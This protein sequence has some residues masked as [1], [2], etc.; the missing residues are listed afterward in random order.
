MSARGVDDG[1]ISGW[2]DSCSNMVG[3]AIVREVRPMRVLRQLNSE[4]EE[5]EE[6]EE[7][8]G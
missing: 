4:G 5:K 1:Y 2:S 7:E 3:V 6:E 8:N